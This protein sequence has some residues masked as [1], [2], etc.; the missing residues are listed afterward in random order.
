MTAPADVRTAAGLF[1]SRLLMGLPVLMILVVL[2]GSCSSGV[3]LVS[4]PDDGAA[5]SI[6]AT[7][8]TEEFVDESASDGSA[9]DGS[10]VDEQASAEDPE[11]T[12]EPTPL[13]ATPVP[14]TPVP[15]TPEPELL[16]LPV[17]GPT[18][19][20]DLLAGRPGPPVSCSPAPA[21]TTAVWAAPNWQV[22]D[23]RDLVL[24]SR[25]EDSRSPT[26]TTGFSETP[27]TLESLGGSA[28]GSRTFRWDSGDTNLS[29]LGVP[30]DS[31]ALG[32]LDGLA[33]PA[34][35]YRVD[36]ILQLEAVENADELRA[37][38]GELYG[39]LAQ[40]DPAVADAG[41]QFI[42]SLP[43]EALGQLFAGDVMITHILEG[44]ELAP[45]ELIE[46]PD[47][48]PNNFG[49]RPFPATTRVALSELV[50]EDGCV[51]FEL[52]T[53]LGDE[54]LPILL[55]S[56]SALM[57]L[58]LN[59]PDIAAEAE[60]FRIETYVVGQYDSAIEQFR[61]V[62]VQRSVVAADQSRLDTSFL[63]DVTPG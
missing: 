14:P 49:G 29:A 19:A 11:P 13:P 52:A 30:P 39:R 26:T 55:E 37:F 50:D 12:D 33:V 41:A 22:G 1:P 3:T 51:R 42:G 31:A 27:V 28:S 21:D 36:E 61:S 54:A 35:T 60:Q 38:A 32:L 7:S 58:D 47:L 45:G 15:P 46:V 25:R 48:L 59:D 9:G 6:G 44:F 10:A 18:G 17:Y 34:I 4:M 16:Q 43:D 53:V 24:Y 20:P 23:V 2:V 8:A 63:L 56:L 5:E 62:A 40:V 57:G